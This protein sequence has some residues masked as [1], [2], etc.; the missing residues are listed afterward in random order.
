[1]ADFYYRY[2]N[3]GIEGSKTVLLNDAYLGSVAPFSSN[4]NRRFRAQDY[5]ATTKV[6]TDSAQGKT[7]TTSVNVASVSR[8]GDKQY[9]TMNVVQF[10]SSDTIAFNN[11]NLSSYTVF[12]ITRYTGQNKNRM[13]NGIESNWFSG[14]HGGF[15]GVAYHEAWISANVD[16]HGN[17]FFIGTDVASSYSTNGILRGTATP[18][19]TTLPKLAINLG[20][21]TPSQ[22]SDGQLLDL[23]MYNRQLSD[24]EKRR[25][26]HYLASYYGIL[27]T[28]GTLTASYNVTPTGTSLLVSTTASPNWVVYPTFQP[29]TTGLSFSMWFKT[30]I[31]SN[32]NWSRLFDFGV[33][34]TYTISMGIVG[35]K[36]VISTYEATKQ[37]ELGNV[38]PGYN[39]NLGINDNVWRHLVWTISADGTIW[40][41]YVNR[42]LTATI[43]ASNYTNYSS[44]GTR[45]PYHPSSTLRTTNFIGKSNTGSDPAFSGSIDEF[46]MFNREITPEDIQ[47]PLVMTNTSLIQPVYNRVK[48]ATETNLLVS[49]TASPNWIIYPSFPIEQT[50]LSFS[51]WFKTDIVSSSQWSR[52]FDFGI[53]TT[54]NISMGIV[55]GNLVISTHE[56]TKQCEINVLTGCN[57]NVWRHLVWTISVDGL[58]WKIY[59]NR[60][61]KETITAS[62]YT[63]YSSSGTRGPYHPSSTMRTSNFI[64]KSN[65]SDPAFSGAIDEFRMFNREIGVNDIVFQNKWFTNVLNINPT[66]YIRIKQTTELPLL[67]STTASPNY[68]F[69][70]SFYIQQTGLTIA[71]WFQSN[72]TANNGRLFDFGNG[73]SLNNIAVSIINNNLSLTTYETGIMCQLD[74]VFTGCNDNV[75]RHFVWTISADGTTWKIYINKVLQATITASNYLNYTST[76]TRGPYH[77]SAN[78]RSSNYIGKSNASSIPL[79]GAIDDFHVYNYPLDQ[80]TINETWNMDTNGS[81][82]PRYARERLPSETSMLVSTTDNKNNILYPS[83]TIQKTGMTFAFW[84]KAN[85]TPDGSI[86]MN[87][88][89]GNADNDIMINIYLSNVTITVQNWNGTPRLYSKSSIPF[90][91]NNNQWR[92]FV[93]TISADGLV[94]TIYFDKVLKLAINSSNW[95][96]YQTN[97]NV[98]PYH[99]ELV[100]RNL[101][102]IGKSNTET[103]PYFNGSL[104]AFQMWNRPLAQSEISALYTE[105]AFNGTYTLSQFPNIQKVYGS[106]IFTLSN[107]TSTGTGTFTFTSSNTAVAT[108]V[109]NVVTLVGVGTTTITALQWTETITATLTVIQPVYSTPALQNNTDTNYQVMMN[110]TAYDLNQAILRNIRQTLNLKWIG[111]QTI[112]LGSVV[113]AYKKNITCTLNGISQLG[114]T[115]LSFGKAKKLMWVLGGATA[116]SLSYSYDGISWTGLGLSL[117][118]AVSGVVWNGT[119]WVAVGIKTV[120]FIANSYDGINWT[121]KA[122]PI[123]STAIYDVA[124]NGKMFVVVGRGTNSIGYS[125]NGIDWYAVARSNLDIF[126]TFGRGIGWNGRMWVAV[127]TGTYKIAYSYDGIQWFPNTTTVLDSGYGITYDGKKWIAVGSGTNCIADSVDGITWTGRGKAFFTSECNG[128]ASNGIVTVAIGKGNTTMAYTYGNNIWNAISIPTLTDGVSVKWN[129]TLFLAISN[130]WPTVFYSYDGV[131]WNSVDS[132]MAFGNSVN[133]NNALEHQIVLKERT[134]VLAS[135]VTSG[136]PNSLS[137]SYDGFS[138]KGLGSS[139]FDNYCS[140]VLNNGTLW[141][142][143]G[144]NNNTIAYSYDG[145]NWTGLGKTAINGWGNAIGYNGTLWLAG[146]YSSGLFKQIASSTTGTSFTGVA[147]PFS[148]S[149]MGFAWNGKL[150]V[151]VG[152][153]TQTIAWS[154]DGTTWSIVSN[155]PLTVYGLGVTWNGQLF[156]ACGEGTNTL[157]WSNDGKLWTAGTTA[158]GDKTSILSGRFSS[159]KWNGKMWIAIGGPT[160]G[161]IGAGTMVYSYDGK[162]WSQVNVS[163]QNGATILWDGKKWIAG[164]T[165]QMFNAGT[166]EQMVYSYDGFTWSN[167]NTLNAKCIAYDVVEPDVYLYMNQPTVAVGTNTLATKVILYSADGMAWTNA[168][169]SYLT[170]GQCVAWNGSMWIVGGMGAA[171]SMIYSYD[172]INWNPIP[173][174]KSIMNIVNGI[175]YNGSLWVAGGSSLAYSLDGINWTTTTQS[176][177]EINEVFW[178]GT[179]WMIGGQANSSMAYSYDGKNWTSVTSTLTI[180]QSI[181]YYDKWV[182]VGAGSDNLVYSYDGINWAGFSLFF[183]TVKSIRHNGF[184]WVATGEGAS[185]TLAYSYDG[186]SWT[187][188]GK[189]IFSSYGLSVTWNGSKWIATGYGTNSIAYSVDGKNWIGLGTTLLEMGYGV[190]CQTDTKSI[191]AKVTTDSL[192]FS[193]DVAQTGY[194]SLSIGVKGTL[195]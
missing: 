67:V 179:M 79:I 94:Y 160:Y 119:L 96:T 189:T 117:M 78:M 186:F 108:I 120:P 45:G 113:N 155:P 2:N 10:S 9:R 107:P 76:G 193:V 42:V 181:F 173:N 91:V 27:D 55:S 114:D 7:A 139:I 148:D 162:I 44:S 86:M 60:I 126:S 111:I 188:L 39:N 131:T 191:D 73:A 30:D 185:H 36:L 192:S 72:A 69:Y 84:F 156:V 6:W 53:G 65:T 141:V 182:A 81:L 118:T 116:N 132:G 59:V 110:G 85:S 80:T 74:N 195:Y 102:Y 62:N 104:H 23:L 95:Q 168:T 130:S 34:A 20:Q 18:G 8:T 50:G 58:T 184:M 163:I 138:W 88:G 147:S 35:G 175:A 1:M 71:F 26:E 174:S 29:E 157:C 164:T 21:A 31:A 122:C 142:A 90:N 121:S 49:T 70:P 127:G 48:L 43:T 129:G 154:T 166:T 56:A 134:Y 146:G 128:I 75:W 83:F 37:C 158:T 152:Y 12:T 61:L 124:W 133:H 125:Y 165:Q 144:S 15:S 180:A 187:G 54:Y 167:L 41:I 151:A 161:I 150:W 140:C 169:Q 16:V 98:A 64:G 183:T 87:F 105:T 93:W 77:P 101:N 153:W 145:I 40:K 137:Y 68:I 171:Y 190:A 82:I 123:F 178:N 170:I 194:K 159:A 109:D 92:H 149:C 33:G 24:P 89:T 28:P 3:K 135:F 4:L 14:H 97:S 136:N 177:T 13:I 172:G 5:N 112:G 17:N 100:L 57:D 66:S 22:N 11:D 25:V 19:V 47:F 32:S 176:F 106:G 63:N 52:L 46:R 115:Q 99:P 103:T 38:L 143:S 51:M